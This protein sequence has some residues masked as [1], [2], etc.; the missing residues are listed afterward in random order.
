[1]ISL[2]VTMTSSTQWSG[3][4]ELVDLALQVTIRLTR[5]TTAVRKPTVQTCIVW[6]TYF[7]LVCGKQNRS[8]EIPSDSNAMSAPHESPRGLV[9]G[10]PEGRSQTKA[11]WVGRSHPG[12]SQVA[13]IWESA[14]LNQHPLTLGLAD[15]HPVS[16]T[17][18]GPVR[19]IIECASESDQ[20]YPLPPTR[21]RVGFRG[22]TDVNKRLYENVYSCANY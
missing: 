9:S 15:G 14:G 4:V 2:R 10:T 8:D 19:R 21:K 5:I 12:L 1:M 22:V 20:A 11:P 3:S 16:P 6:H 13:S 18:S 17:T 7:M